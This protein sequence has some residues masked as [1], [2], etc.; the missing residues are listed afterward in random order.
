[1][2]IS[3]NIVA[4][5]YTLGH[6]VDMKKKFEGQVDKIDPKLLIDT[7]RQQKDLDAFFLVLAV[8]YND[9][10]GLIFFQVLLK[11]VYEI[12]D[13]T[14]PSYHLGE[15]GGLFV[16]LHKINISLINEFFAFLQKNEEVIGSTEFMLILNGI[17][18]KV[19]EEWRDIV[20]VA[21]EK[22][23]TMSDFAKALVKIRHNVGF[24][25]NQNLKNLEKAFLSRFSRKSDFL[26]KF[27][28]YA[29]GST[30]EDTRY[31]YADAAVG[32]YLTM[33]VKEI[34]NSNMTLESFLKNELG[35]I[36]RKMNS[37]LTAL[38]NEYLR[39]RKGVK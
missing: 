4:A 24:H 39:R 22:Q 16:Q 19:K 21:F 15:Y 10:K 33:V 27:A 29:Q 31:F 7:N 18:T 37:V 34:N 5:L 14:Q 36:T 32:E 26:S 11:E 30:M 1:M 23:G 8:I 17:N 3:G 2:K 9:L 28:F 35:P 12:P 6:Y 20:H 38:I 13:Q 25:Y